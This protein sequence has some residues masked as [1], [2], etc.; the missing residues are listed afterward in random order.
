MNALPFARRVVSIIFLSAVAS[1]TFAGCAAMYLR[2]ADC[3]RDK[4]YA[5]GMN[6][7]QHGHMMNEQ[8]ADMCAPADQSVVH[9]GYRA[10]YQDGR[11]G[12]TAPVVVA[13][14][15]GNGGGVVVAGPPPRCIEAYGK[16]ACGYDCKEAYGNLACGRTPD[17]NCV[18]AYGKLRC[19]VACREHFGQIECAGD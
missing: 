8:V 2:G 15:A 3:N 10:G 6:D 18:E 4:A 7:G 17:E 12:T 1:A 16:R 19:G 11:A 5:R 13:A 14:I 9:E